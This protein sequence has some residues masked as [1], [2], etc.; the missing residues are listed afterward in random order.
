MYQ[1]KLKWRQSPIQHTKTTGKG[2]PANQT[3][4]KTSQ[5]K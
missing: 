3:D 4:Q 2:L 5:L 1:R